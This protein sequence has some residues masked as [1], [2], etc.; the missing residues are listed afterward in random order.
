V[1]GD[2][3]ESIVLLVYVIRFVMEGNP[4]GRV[5]KPSIN[6]IDV[7]REDPMPCPVIDRTQELISKHKK[8]QED[9]Q[10]R[11]GKALGDMINSIDP[12]PVRLLKRLK[13]GHH[14]AICQIEEVLRSLG[15]V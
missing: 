4:I 8:I 11:S 3:A 9:N 13:V 5:F 10:A 7:L 14:R 15:E 6:D 12:D 2:G 1:S